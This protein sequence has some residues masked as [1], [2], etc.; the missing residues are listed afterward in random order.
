M[1]YDLIILIEIYININL[2]LI[3]I[4]VLMNREIVEKYRDKNDLRIYKVILSDKGEQLRNILYSDLDQFTSKL[5]NALDNNV[6]DEIY[7]FDKLIQ[8]LDSHEI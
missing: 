1:E 7:L 4:N 3:N 5:L 2:R 6:Q 8:K